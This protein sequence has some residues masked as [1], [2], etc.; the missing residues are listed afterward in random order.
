MQLCGMVGIRLMHCGWGE[1]RQAA[2]NNVKGEGKGKVS[3]E[4]VHLQ[5]RPKL[6]IERLGRRLLCWR[7]LGSR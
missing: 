4:R 7:V 3:A 2:V 5:P 1:K 6:T